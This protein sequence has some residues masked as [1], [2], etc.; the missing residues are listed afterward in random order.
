L[1][2]KEKVRTGKEGAM[3]VRRIDLERDVLY[4]RYVRALKL[5]GGPEEESEPSPGHAIRS[6]AHC[7]RHT[8]FRLDSEGTWFECLRCGHFA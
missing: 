1:I 3:V 8:M 4:Q 7:G 6:C 5:W 2:R